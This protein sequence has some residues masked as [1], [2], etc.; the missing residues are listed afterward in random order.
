M[1]RLRD[2][3]AQSPLMEKAQAL[4][5]AVPPLPESHERMQR[6]RRELDRPRGMLAAMRRAPALALAALVALFGASAFAAV[7]Y[8]T[9]RPELA[10]SSAQAGSDAA[11]RVHHAAKHNEHSAT[12]PE[13][14]PTAEPGQAV[15]D[16]RE[17]LAP[18]AQAAEPRANTSTHG[19]A[20]AG[21][22]GRAA[23][24]AAAPRVEAH[25]RATDGELAQQTD[26]EHARASDSELVHRALKALRRD[27]DAA[28][29][30][31]LLDENRKRYPGG[32]LAEE[33]LS[34]QIEAALA[35]HD[36]RAR[37]F[38]REYVARYPA[39]RY[40][41]IAQHALTSAPP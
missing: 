9:A 11:K 21:A 20:G 1:K 29:A 17:L 40:L 4:I 16:R 14:A 30:A 39:G 24:H 33:A 23:M 26:G 8:L 28:L 35:L 3:D 7:R 12:L 32:P 10:A 31:R 6:V 36:A 18:S 38:A 19:G 25:A 2:G 22:T 5:D 13:A 15:P 37:T 41:Q 34:L 27:G